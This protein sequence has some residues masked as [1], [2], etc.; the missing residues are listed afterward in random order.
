MAQAGALGDGGRLFILDMGEPVKI[1]DLIRNLITLSGFRP[2]HDIEIRE[3][4]ARPG[5]KI[6]EEILTDNLTVERTQTIT[7][8][9]RLPRANIKIKAE[10]RIRGFGNDGCTENLKI[11]P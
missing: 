3:T 11:E 7:L 1:I 4:G 2:D 6:F 5:E 9:D 10:G 8:P